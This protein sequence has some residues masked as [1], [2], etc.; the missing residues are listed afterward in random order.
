MHYEPRPTKVNA[1][2]HL[3]LMFIGEMGTSGLKEKHFFNYRS[4]ILIEHNRL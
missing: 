3:V 4:K 2:F 1:D